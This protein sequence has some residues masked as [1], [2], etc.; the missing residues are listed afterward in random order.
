M[1]K[2]PTNEPTFI[3]R[4]K[5]WNMLLLLM[6]K[7]TKISRKKIKVGLKIDF[8]MGYC[9]GVKLFVDVFIYF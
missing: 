2:N 9:G 5:I 4:N 6:Q 7:N 1:P 8:R 3:D